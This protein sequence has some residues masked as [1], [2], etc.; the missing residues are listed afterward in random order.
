MI[1]V[2]GLKNCDNCR[3][4]LKW[5]SGERIVTTFHDFR[6]EGLTVDKLNVW[7]EHVD[8]NILLNRR[9]TTWRKLSERAKQNLNQ[10]NAI[11]LMMA[12]ISL[13]KRPVFEVKKKVL[14]GATEETLSI[15]K[16]LT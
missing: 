4:A 10:N 13:I 15:I 14:I 16:N 9:G 12:N 3:K 5:L 6:L 1:H 11:V 2:Y 7:L 8:W